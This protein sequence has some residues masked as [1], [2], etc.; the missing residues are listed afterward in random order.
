MPTTIASPPIRTKKLGLRKNGASAREYGSN[1]RPPVTL[2]GSVI[3]R[4]GW[5]DE[6]ATA[7]R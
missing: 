3:R 2:R 5:G 6:M 7:A 1:R 4:L